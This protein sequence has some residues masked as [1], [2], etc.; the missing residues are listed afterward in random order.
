MYKALIEL[1]QAQSGLYSELLEASRQKRAYLVNSDIDAIRRVTARENGLIGKLRK[2]ER[3]REKITGNLTAGL[4][5]PAGGLTLADLI[6]R[7]DDISLRAQLE[8]LRLRVR[9]LMD[10]LKA[11]NEQ[12]KV[13]INQSLEYIDF[14][15]NLLR[16][17]VS[18]PEYPGMEEIH[19]Q[20]FFDARG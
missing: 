18:V 19:G 3:E 14:S 12:N 5:V 1:L 20:V 7:V 17:A 2:A 6:S 15:M 4:P 13:L 16:N 9:S 10:D 8:N 11:V